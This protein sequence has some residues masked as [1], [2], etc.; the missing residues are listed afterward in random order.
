MGFFDAFRKPKLSNNEVLQLLSSA[1]IGISEKISELLTV[2]YQDDIKKVETQA[3]AAFFTTR[4]YFAV[5]AYGSSIEQISD[6]FAK[7]IYMWG[8]HISNV[9]YSD[10]KIVYDMQ[11][12]VGLDWHPWLRERLEH[13]KEVHEKDRI[14]TTIDSYLQLVNTPCNIMHKLECEMYIRTKTAGL[15]T[16]FITGKVPT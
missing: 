16:M 2:D 1:T 4:S 3:L 6:N 13:Y 10:P 15:T 14:L 7:F 12:G 5:I 9:D 8:Y 11:H